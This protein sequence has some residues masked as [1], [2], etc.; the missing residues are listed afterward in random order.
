MLT[1]DH[2][3][4]AHHAHRQ[5]LLRHFQTE[6]DHR[7]AVARRH[8][9]SH[10]QHERGLAHAGPGGDED[11]V[12]A[13]EAT[14]QLVEVGEPGGN[15]GNA[16]LGLV[17]LVDFIQRAEN[18][19]LD[20]LEILAGLARRH[21]EN[22]L[23]RR[24]QHPVDLLRL[25]V[26]HGGDVRGGGDQSAQQAFFLHDLGVEGDVGGGGHA[27]GERSDVGDAA[28][29]LQRVF[30]AEDV[31][32]RDEVDGLAAFEQAQGGAINQ[33]VRF[34]VEILGIEHVRNLGD[35]ALLDQHGAQH[36]LFGLDVLRR[37]SIQHGVP[38]LHPRTVSSGHLPRFP[39]VAPTGRDDLPEYP[40]H[41]LWG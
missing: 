39:S 40:F 6:D 37:H 31:N 22:L 32:D 18:D 27:I 36:G 16:A 3:L 28:G 7:F 23:F 12:G 15:A 4:G 9:L 8:V 30:A 13:L 24:I 29:L 26:A 35:G 25:G 19:F 34:P 10:V 1:V 33:P 11:Q 38:F 5:L 41:F 14:G 2:A 20:G 21:L 17:H